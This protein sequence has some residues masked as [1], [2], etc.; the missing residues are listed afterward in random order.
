MRRSSRKYSSDS[1]HPLEPGSGNGAAASLPG[2]GGDL[3][4]LQD[5]PAPALSEAPTR[6]GIIRRKRRSAA[7]PRASA[8]W[9]LLEKL[10]LPDNAKSGSAYPLQRQFAKYGL[11]TG[12]IGTVVFGSLVAGLAFFAL[13][14]NAGLL[15]RREEAPIL[16]FCL[17]YQ[18]LFAVVGYLWFVKT[19]NYPGNEVVG[20][21]RGAV[22]LSLVG[23]TCLALGIRFGIRLW[24]GFNPK[25]AARMAGAEPQYGVFFLFL[26]TFAANLSG[27]IWKVNPM[28][29]WFGGAQILYRLL[30]FKSVLLVLL[31]IT[32]LRQGKGYGYAAIAGLL[33]FVSS[34]GSTMSAFSFALMLFLVAALREWRPWLSGPLDKMKNRRIEAIAVG[35]VLT[36]FAMGLVWEGAVKSV[37]RG[38]VLNEEGQLTGQASA[39]EFLQTVR[40]QSVTLRFEDALDS[41]AQRMSSD[42]LYFSYVIDRVPAEVPHENGMLT[43][44]ALMHV[45]MPRFLFPNKENLGSDSWLVIQYAGVGAAGAEQG[46]SIGLGYIAEFYIDYGIPWMFLPLLIYGIIIGLSYR[47]LQWFS[48]SHAMW[49]SAATVM[50]F[51]AFASYGGELAKLFGT[52]VLCVGIYSIILITAGRWLHLGLATASLGEKRPIRGGVRARPAKQP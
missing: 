16:P 23:F 27:L 29:M 50:C 17:S 6:R 48:P 2:A 13:F 40:E 25:T 14:F 39:R 10:K 4:A 35:L 26:L 7:T 47:V 34:F 51:G 24:E 9:S 19:G 33:V 11:I 49:M 45:L 44:R 28:G 42:A 20:N 3:Q 41:V 5:A 12:V 1:G 46:T 22:L 21:I 52:L 15:W 31:W 38:Q 32:V 8:T 37:W 18:W 43:R 30:E 36:V